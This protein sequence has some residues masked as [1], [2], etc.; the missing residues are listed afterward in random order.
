MT[1]SDTFKNLKYIK[2]KKDFTKG[3]A[4]FDEGHLPH[5]VLMVYTYIHPVTEGSQTVTHEGFINERAI[6]NP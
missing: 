6:L 5:K 1:V 4:T 3:S 2:T